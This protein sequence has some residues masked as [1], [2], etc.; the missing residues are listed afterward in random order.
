MTTPRR[1]F[2][3]QGEIR[4]SEDGCV[5]KTVLGSCVSVCLWDTVRGVGGLNH[6]MLPRGPANGRDARFGDVAIPLLI[7][8]LDALGCTD[9]VAKVFGGARVAPIGATGT[10][11]DANTELAMQVLQRHRIPLAAQRTGGT[12]GV[13]VHYFSA[14]GD[15]LLRPI[16][17]APSVAAR[18]HHHHRRPAMHA[19]RRPKGDR[20]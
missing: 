7:E 5:F 14:S 16:T 18:H 6:Y 3:Q 10:V 1:V 13:V 12:Q 2:L 19:H 11:G 17:G 15:A 9:L 8:G 4:W 20:V